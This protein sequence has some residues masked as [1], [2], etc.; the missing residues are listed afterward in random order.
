[1]KSTMKTN[2]W[3]LLF[4]VLFATVGL[5]SVVGCG[6]DSKGS[7]NSS[8]A[9]YYVNNG[10]CYQRSNNQ[11]VNMS[12]CTTTGNNGYY[13]NGYACVQTNNPQVQV[14]ASYC[15]GT[16]T[17]TGNYQLI[18]G[19]CYD[20]TG[21]VQPASYCQGNQGGQ[22]VGWYYYYPGWGYPQQVYCNGYN[23][24]GYQLYNQN[25]VQVYCQ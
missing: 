13:W 3:T 22:C 12:Y 10:Y 6:K 23:C 24:R 25:N 5:M 11:M 7:N 19:S 18:N 17:T 15:S 21:V 16:N 2:K 14:P 9:Y 20:S 4:K 8:N 1:M